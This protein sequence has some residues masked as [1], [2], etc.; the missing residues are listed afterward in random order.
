VFD[1]DA[2]RGVSI[3]VDVSDPADPSGAEGGELGPASSP[4]RWISP[5]SLV[6]A[7]MLILFGVAA[8]SILGP[9]IGG[10]GVPDRSIAVLPLENLSPD[11]ENQYFADGIHEDV[12]TQLSKI[13]DLKVI[14]RTSVLEYRGVERN[15]PEIAAELGVAAVL[16][17]SV[18]RDRDR[19]K[20]R[21]LLGGCAITPRGNFS[22]RDATH[23]GL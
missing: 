2:D 4:P 8:G 11:P 13:A 6:A 19:A 18:R 5:G 22:L 1:L 23:R 9:L 16:E 15:L 12:I 17:G 21:E 3:S 20:H 7:A 10:R 14:S